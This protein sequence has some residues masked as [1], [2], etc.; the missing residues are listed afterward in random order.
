MKS[1]GAT[2]KAEREE[3]EETILSL[4]RPV[5]TE[6]PADSPTEIDRRINEI[7]A[8]YLGETRISSEL[9]LPF[10]S[11]Q[12]KNS[13][14]SEQPVPPLEHIA[15]LEKSAVR[16]SVHT[17][18][19]R[20]IGHMTASLPGFMRSLSRLLTT[21]NQ[22]NVKMETSLGLSPYEREA[23]AKMHR[24]FY[25]CDESFYREHIQNPASTLGIMTSGGTVANITALWC[26]RNA[27]LKPREG[28]P[29]VE[30]TGLH[31]ALANY[32]YRDAVI[33][34]SSALHFSFEKAADLMGLGTNN[35]I[36]IPTGEGQRIDIPALTA[37]LELCRRERRH[38]IAL[39]GVAGT[40]EAGG[41]DNLKAMSALAREH[42]IH[43]HVDAAWGGPLIFSRRHAHLL[44]GIS[45][46]DS[47]TIDG[48]KQLYLP[49][50]NGMVLF[51]DPQLAGYIEKNAPYVIRAGSTDLGKRSLEGSRPAMTIYLQAGLEIIGRNGYEF[52]VDSSIEKIQYM[53]RLI[54]ERNEFELLFKPQMNILL[55]R[56]IPAKFRKKVAGRSLN[57][58]ENQIINNLNT[59]L[60][61][62][63]RVQSRSFVSRT[64]ISLGH[65]DTFIPIVALRAVI[66][67]P[68]T[69]KQDIKSVLE[70]QLTLMAKMEI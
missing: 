10:I 26:A 48:H 33:I 56:Y 45:L 18:H 16:H 57:P 40:T 12:Y 15:H 68:L 34:G 61:K 30:K 19:P 8:A 36:R 58:A 17:H 29:G 59:V 2:K 6:T 21:M 64:T 51:R 39:V 27:S 66:S 65:D 53:A 43:F 37:E 11:E 9:G 5:E 55:Y 42:D 22:N 4:F 67:N 7:I 50:G 13:L 14:I 41:I 20:Y 1:P 60:Q 47:I 70:E 49:M 3:L 31:R 25:P 69:T 62:T 32:E 63:Q 44:E 54:D 46:A 24:L 38:V 52:L 35:L 23:L 28:F